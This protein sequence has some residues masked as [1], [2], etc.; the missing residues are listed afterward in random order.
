MELLDNSN[1]VSV[2]STHLEHGNQ[3]GRGCG[4]MSFLFFFL[5]PVD[6][7]VC[8]NGWRLAPGSDVK[9]LFKQVLLILHIY[10]AC[11]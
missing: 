4:Q 6:L 11:R 3:R 1:E 10:A 9:L 2:L 5:C 8:V 7:G